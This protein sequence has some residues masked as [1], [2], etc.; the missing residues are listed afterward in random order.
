MY[1]YLETNVDL[2]V[3]TK[4]EGNFSTNIFISP[5]SFVANR[6]TCRLLALSGMSARLLLT[7]YSG[8]VSGFILATA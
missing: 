2:C 3:H 4:F 6:Y 8:S 1:K 7:A 5:F